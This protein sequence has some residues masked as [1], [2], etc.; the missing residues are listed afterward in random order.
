MAVDR[1]TGSGPDF[2]PALSTKYLPRAEVRELPPPPRESWRIIG[3]GLVGAGVGLASGEFILWPYI[4]SQVGLVFLWGAVIGVVSQWFLNMEIERYTLATG[5]T[6][7]TGFS[8]LWKHWGLVFAVMTYFA[9]LWPGWATSSATMVTYIFGGNVTVI[10]IVILVIC[11]AVLTLAPVVYTAL[12][13]VIVVKVAAIVVLI[14]GAVVFAL[15]TDTWRALGS[16]V[17]H[18]GQFPGDLDFALML[19]AIAYAGAGGGQNLCQSNWIRDKRFGMGAYAPRLVSPVTGQDAAV[20]ST[21]YTFAPT[22]PNL[23]HWRGWWRFANIEQAATFVLI[24]CFTIAF[25]SML[26]FATV[27]GRSGLSQDIGF[28]RIEGTA[29]QESVGPWF[30]YF[31]WVIG[32]YALFAAAMG[33]I[34]YTSR[35]GAD[36]LA[37]VYLRR[38]GVSESRVYFWLVWGLVAFGALV[39]LA[40]LDQPLVLLVISSCVS[41]VMMA[42]YGVLLI[43]MN[44]RALPR[45]IQIRNFR[46]IVIALAVAFYGTLGI[47]TI[48][49]QVQKLLE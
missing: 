19:G 30:G 28:L 11:G 41:G 15:T 42:I 5:E 36:L 10:A 38:L 44:K 29:L 25:M 48:I 9:N 49:Q 27:F 16:A 46:T 43:L 23:M 17:T 26:A 47:I 35:L 40:G 21:G 1:S 14:A 45:Q 13:R 4:A 18:A 20:P 3:P 6:A 22:L 8:R 24:T 33:I 7:L 31:F 2:T 34:D 39:L 12:E 37:T 32:A